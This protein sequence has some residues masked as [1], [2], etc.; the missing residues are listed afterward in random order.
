MF[1]NTNFVLFITGGGAGG[2]R[3][4]G[5]GAGSTLQRVTRSSVAP[6]PLPF[7]G[8]TEEQA[9]EAMMIQSEPL[10]K[11]TVLTNQSSANQPSNVTGQSSK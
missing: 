6:S 5:G 1:T 3:G 2:G 11:S 9:I 10:S 7:A 8:D 4:G